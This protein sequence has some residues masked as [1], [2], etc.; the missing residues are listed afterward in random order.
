M[1]FLSQEQ[2]GNTHHQTDYTAVKAGS[3]MLLKCRRHSLSTEKTEQ[4]IFDWSEGWFKTHADLK[5]LVWNR[6]T[7]INQHAHPDHPD[8]KQVLVVLLSSLLLVH[9]EIKI[10]FMLRVN[11]HM[12]VFFLDYF[13]IFCTNPQSSMSEYANKFSADILL[14][15]RLCYST[16]F[17]ELWLLRVY[18]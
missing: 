17:S 4:K 12:D 15:L 9:E 13:C 5:M 16:A 7:L 2:R 8:G 1:W 14:E 6:Y 18:I 10:F 3:V 11:W